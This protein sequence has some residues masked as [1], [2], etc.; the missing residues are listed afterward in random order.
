MPKLQLPSRKWIGMCTLASIDGA[1]AECLPT[2]PEQP[3]CSPSERP[4]SSSSRPVHTKLNNPSTANTPGQAPLLQLAIPACKTFSGL[5]SD[6]EEVYEGSAGTRTEL[7]MGGAGGGNTMHGSIY[8]DTVPHGGGAQ[9][10]DHHALTN[11]LRRAIRGI[12][13]DD[14]G[15]QASEGEGNGSCLASSTS[16]ASLKVP[17]SAGQTATSS[18]SPIGSIASSS[19]TS[20]PSPAQELEE[21]SELQLKGNMEVLTRLGEGASGEV[22]KAMYRPTGQVMAM[23]VSRLQAATSSCELTPRHTDDQHFAQSSR[24]PSDPARTSLQP[25]LPLRVH[26]ALL[27]RLSRQRRHE[28]RHL[29]GAVRG[30]QS[31]RHLQAMQSEKRSNGRKGVGKN[32][33]K[34]A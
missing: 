8:P 20:D 1:D 9:S 11:D 25:H 3:A 33:R 22:R 7:P 30:R 26:C 21:E 28:H 10:S 13:L 19:A 12:A 15:S 2:H 24:P 6:A 17:T 4:H 31:R 34:W 29:H 14:G 23:K 18:S 16:A 27:W 32:C 5:Q